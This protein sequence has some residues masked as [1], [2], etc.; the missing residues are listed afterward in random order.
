MDLWIR[1]Q[2]K[3]TLIKCEK[4]LVEEDKDRFAIVNYIDTRNWFRLGLYKTKERVLEVLDEI[5][6][7]ISQ[8]ECLKTM[9]PKVNDIRGHEEKFGKL[10][11]ETIY[12]MPEE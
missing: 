12:E 3:V 6:G 5:Q 9:M 8:N 4:I 10:F 7:K 11:K 2:D 1:S